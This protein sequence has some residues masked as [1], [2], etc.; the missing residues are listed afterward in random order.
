MTRL[1]QESSNLGATLVLSY[2][3]NGLLQQR[4]V[5]PLELIGEF[6]PKVEIVFRDFSN[7]STFGGP[8]ALWRVP[9]VENVYLGR[10]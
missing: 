5:D 7:H 4:G 6:Y 2:P 3:S 9:V 10:P 8:R 1:A